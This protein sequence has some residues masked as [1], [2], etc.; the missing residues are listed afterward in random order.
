MSCLSKQDFLK[1]HE[2][3]KVKV[4]VAELGGYV[5][6]RSLTAKEII[7]LQEKVK[8]V[9]AA[10]RNLETTCEVLAATLVDDAGELLFSGVDDLKRHLNV[11]V[12]TLNALLDQAFAVSGAGTQKN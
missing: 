5:W 4:D 1:P 10:T 7:D 11:S 8:A 9:D 6:I 3:K 12:E 2:L